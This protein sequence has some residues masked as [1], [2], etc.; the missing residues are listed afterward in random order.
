MRPWV[1][2]SGIVLDNVR[3]EPEEEGF[4][5]SVDPTWLEVL[6]V[7]VVGAESGIAR[8]AMIAART[9]TPT[10]VRSNGFLDLA[11]TVF[12]IRKKRRRKTIRIESD[13][14]D[15]SCIGRIR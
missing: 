15:P 10:S 1:E 2:G 7:E 13:Y 12:P 9:A 4:W 8:P 3:N 5:L 6:L 11:F 14:P